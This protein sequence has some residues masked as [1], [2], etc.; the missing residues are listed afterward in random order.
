MERNWA[1]HRGWSLACYETVLHRDGAKRCHDRA[2]G[3]IRALHGHRPPG[4]STRCAAAKGFFVIGPAGYIRVCNH[5]ANRVEHISTV[6][7]LAT[8]PYW[9]HRERILGTS[10][11]GFA[12]AGARL[13]KDP[14]LLTRLLRTGEFF[15]FTIHGF[16][17]RRYLMAP[18]V[19]DAILL[20]MKT[21]MPWNPRWIRPRRSD[22]KS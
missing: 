15:G 18:L 8:K 12:V 20:A 11:K 19:G 16:T 5:S 7:R 4:A 9:K 14:R 10:G 2:R 22:P 3:G 6:D 1:I 13:T 17:G 21:A